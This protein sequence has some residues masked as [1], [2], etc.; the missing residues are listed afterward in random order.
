MMNLDN[1]ALFCDEIH[2]TL[3]VSTSKQIST[4]EETT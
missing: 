4:S 3:D 1:Q 2:G